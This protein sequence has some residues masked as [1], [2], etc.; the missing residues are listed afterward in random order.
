MLVPGP[1]EK[2]DRKRRLVFCWFSFWRPK[3]GMALRVTKIY[4]ARSNNSGSALWIYKVLK[5]EATYWIPRNLVLAYIYWE[6][7]ISIARRCSQKYQRN[8]T[9]ARVCSF[10]TDASCQC[11]NQTLGKITSHP[12]YSQFSKFRVIYCPN[13]AH[14]PAWRD[15]WICSPITTTRAMATTSC[16]ISASWR[17]SVRKSEWRGNKRCPPDIPLLQLKSRVRQGIPESLRGAVWFLLAQRHPSECQPLPSPPERARIYTVS[18]LL[19]T[20]TEIVEL[21]VFCLLS[22]L[23]I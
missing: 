18:P 9:D 21:A 22:R 11:A 10:H 1:R 6:N 3:I 20:V 23:S 16:A 19:Y 5:I 12:Q 17:S 13:F 14:V 7:K 15:H 8:F 4:R 2:L